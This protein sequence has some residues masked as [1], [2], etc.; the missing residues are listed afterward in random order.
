MA[1]ISTVFEDGPDSS[2][3]E[4]ENLDAE[5]KGLKGLLLSSITAVQ[6]IGSFATFGCLEQIVL[7]SISVG[8]VGPIRL[9]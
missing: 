8:A 5:L 4:N 2:D 7:P 3:A 9:P 1:T 6:A